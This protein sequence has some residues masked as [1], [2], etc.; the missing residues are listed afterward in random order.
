MLYLKSLGEGPV[1][2]E[3]PTSERLRTVL[4]YMRSVNMEVPNSGWD[5]TKQQS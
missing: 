4:T 2:T 5:L 1:L 3:K